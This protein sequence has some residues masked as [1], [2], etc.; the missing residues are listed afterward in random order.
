MTEEVQL[1][2]THMEA[3]PRLAL[4]AV[5]ASHLEPGKSVG[6]VSDDSDVFFILLSVSCEMRGNLYFRQGKKTVGKGIEYHNVSSLAEHLAEPCCRN[7]PAFHALT[8]CDF[9]FAFFRRSKLTSFNMMMNMKKSK[10]RQVTLHQLDTLG[11]ENVNYDDVLDFIVH[12]IYNRPA[13]EKSLHESRKEMIKIGKGEK[14]KYRSTRLV[15]PDK[16]SLIMKIKRANLI[17]VPWKT[18]LD[19]NVQSLVPKENGW[20]EKDGGLVPKWFE[21][22]SLPSDEVYDTHVAE[23]MHLAI[24]EECENEYECSENTDSESDTDS[25]YA[26][27]DTYSSSDEED[28]L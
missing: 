22:N 21:G 20:D 17:T 15:I 27:S 18:C 25:E 3:D 2:C 5:F 26:M 4:H 12:T 9:T 14:R 1:E 8:G 7:L 23:L 19:T 11:T 10:K 24:Q 28:E 16:S 6:V 13:K